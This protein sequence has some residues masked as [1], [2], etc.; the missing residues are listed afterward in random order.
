MQNLPSHGTSRPSGSSPSQAVPEALAS[1]HG[2]S[3]NGQA[4][5]RPVKVPAASTPSSSSSSSSSS[6]TTTGESPRTG[7]FSEPSSPPPLH[8]RDTKL[9][10]PWISGQG[11]KPDGGDEDTAW[12]LKA[13]GP[14]FGQP[15]VSA[16]PRVGEVAQV[17]DSTMFRW[18]G[19]VHG[20]PKVSVEDAAVCTAMLMR[21]FYF[22]RS[23]WQTCED[24]L[25]AVIAASLGKAAQDQP[26]KTAAMLA[27]ICR[28]LDQLTHG[29]T[30]TPPSSGRVSLELRATVAA[31]IAAPLLP[32]EM[33]GRYVRECRSERLLEA[34]IRALGGR[35][36]DGKTPGRLLPAPPAFYDE[37]PAEMGRW[38]LSR[39]ME[40]LWRKD[41]TFLEGSAFL[42]TVEADEE[43]DAWHRSLAGG[44]R[45]APLASP[46]DPQR[47][48]TQALHVAAIQR[49]LRDMP[50]EQV[51]AALDALR[52]R[53]LREGPD[54]PVPVLV[55]TVCA[56]ATGLRD[57]EEVN[58]EDND[59]DPASDLLPAE[60]KR[61]LSSPLAA[62]LPP[63]ALDAIRD[64][65]SLTRDPVAWLGRQRRDGSDQGRDLMCELVRVALAVRAGFAPDEL[66]DALRSEALMRADPCAAITTVG[67]LLQQGLRLDEQTLS[68]VRSAIVNHLHVLCLERDRLVIQPP[69]GAVRARYLRVSQ[70]LASAE[71]QRIPEVYQG[72]V[73]H[74]RLRWKEFGE[75][76]SPAQ[77]QRYAKA[78]Q[79]AARALHAQVKPWREEAKALMGLCAQVPDAI[80]RAAQDLD[81][82]G[83]DVEASTLGIAS[84]SGPGARAVERALRELPAFTAMS[85]VDFA[86]AQRVRAAVVSLLGAHQGLDAGTLPLQDA[87]KL[88]DATGRALASPEENQIAAAVIARLCGGSGMDETCMDALVA[89]ALGG[90]PGGGSP[91]ARDTIQAARL[92]AGL[93]LG[94]H[95][96]PGTQDLPG[97]A[98]AEVVVS[99]TVFLSVVARWMM[100]QDASPAVRRERIGAFTTHVLARSQP[101]WLGVFLRELAATPARPG[102]AGA[103]E[104][105]FM[106]VVEG[107]HLEH[108]GLSDRDWHGLLGHLMEAASR[109]AAQVSMAMAM[110]LLSG[111]A[112]RQ[113]KELPVA[114][115]QMLRF[116]AVRSEPVSAQGR[117]AAV[118]FQSLRQLRQQVAQPGV[119][120]WSPR[121]ALDGLA[122]A[123]VRPP[124]ILARLAAVVTLALREVP[125]ELAVTRQ[126]LFD[127]VSAHDAVLVVESL[128]AFDA[129][130]LDRLAARRREVLA[131]VAALGAG[132][133]FGMAW[134]LPSGQA[135]GAT[136]AALREAL[137]LP[138]RAGVQ[139]ELQEALWTGAQQGL[140][141]LASSKLTQDTVEAAWE[142]VMVCIGEAD[143]DAPEGSK[144]RRTGTG[145][146]RR[147]PADPGNTEKRKKRKPGSAGGSGSSGASGT[148]GQPPAGVP[149]QPPA[150]DVPAAGQHPP[151]LAAADP[152][153][154]FR[155]ALDRFS[156]GLSDAA[157]SILLAGPRQAL[158]TW[159]GPL[160]QTGRRSAS[161]AARR[162]HPADSAEVGEMLER[163]FGGFARM[164][165]EQ[166][167]VW[168]EAG[169]DLRGLAQMLEREMRAWGDLDTPHV[170][171][172]VQPLRWAQEILLAQADKP[173][174][175]PMRADTKVSAETKS[176]SAR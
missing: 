120:A 84:G 19:S 167:L 88:L 26:D 92:L 133:A 81:A 60:R 76:W 13:L 150:P 106:A 143:D 46:L 95:G 1:D 127:A 111:A 157:R 119:A 4:W 134:A 124:Q 114:L 128:E 59:R 93:W 171:R 173:R 169:H 53:I 147:D 36:Q 85:H 67:L 54:W 35:E 155:L 49:A 28:A 110:A 97:E 156:E 103:T 21:R 135:A 73:E 100:A 101:E 102:D 40:I 23:S 90:A 137:R 176:L 80:L 74:Q 163:L 66:S 34:A 5:G 115:T 32:V 122:L 63:A 64:G 94:L 50:S 3:S 17:T 109:P 159:L 89:C 58:A 141:A 42:G 98:E 113:D 83:R 79:E 91:A 24:L 44:V 104:G 70:D 65:F 77:C 168:H 43:P 48:M 69:G 8:R 71:R 39:G 96:S 11:R 117:L 165:N 146:D 139:A 162:T 82:L 161:P 31:R 18:L 131:Q 121:E 61:F 123:Q 153:V 51:D 6:F 164:V 55:A 125:A 158:A 38:C 130:A 75:G 57:T 152:Q 154:Q 45:L 118:A 10:A 107:L 136:N 145:R 151:V 138:A 56:H 30:R 12:V 7:P 37:C 126:W 142:R 172:V 170:R 14:S 15:A 2:A 9:G 149:P 78:L 33:L 99:A 148:S 68:L 47:A 20:D 27:G 22:K 174:P 41:P 87:V 16:R 25:D 108:R 116:L 129:G 144:S 62:R 105:N 29:G 72:I 52:E 112:G 86:N 140:E 160:V 175:R 132:H 166:V